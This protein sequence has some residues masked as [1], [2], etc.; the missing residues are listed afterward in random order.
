MVQELRVMALGDWADDCLELSR[1]GAMHRSRCHGEHDIQGAT[2]MGTWSHSWS[3]VAESIVFCK[4]CSDAGWRKQIV[5][6]ATPQESWECS[7]KAR[8]G[9]VRQAMQ[10]AAE[11]DGMHYARQGTR[12]RN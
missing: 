9:R 6:P 2:F 11:H 10:Q 8:Q 4:P 12:I 7:G 1:C 3:M 5:R